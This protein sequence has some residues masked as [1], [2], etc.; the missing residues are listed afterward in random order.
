VARRIDNP[1]VLKPRPPA[2]AR[3]YLYV[4]FEYVDGRTLAQW[5]RDQPA[6]RLD[7]VRTIV[8]QIA[9]GLRAFHRL[10]MLH[11]DLR[12]ENVMIDG[13][14]VVRI[15]DFGAARVAGLAE[16]TAPERADEALGTEQY[17]A[18]EYLLGEGGTERSD[19]FSLAVITYQMLSGRLPYGAQVARLRTRAALSKLNYDSVLD[20]RRETPA[21]LDGVLRKALHPNPMKRHEAL[22]EFVHDLR[23]PPREFLARQRT[24]WVERNPLLFWKGLALA[25]GLLAL[26]LLVALQR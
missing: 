9:A 13:A 10:E 18:P 7:A 25:L 15:I 4:V 21:W 2:R 12:P 26:G 11:Q 19:L 20:R 23:H 14:G 16:M 24:P 17:M 1:H 6:P 22:S 8:E 3:S 5:M